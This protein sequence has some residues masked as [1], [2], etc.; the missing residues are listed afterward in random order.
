MSEKSKFGFADISRHRALIMGFAALWIYYF[1]I[2]PVGIFSFFPLDKIEWYLH[3]E[4]FCGVDIFLLLSSFGLYYSM[5]K[6]PVNDAKSYAGYLKSRFVRIFCVLIPIT[7]VIGFVD[8]WSLREFCLK[9]TGIDMLARDMYSY[10]WFVPCILIFYILSPFYFAVFKRFKKKFAFTL[11]AVVIAVALAFAL[12]N[13]I[14]YDLY[15]I[16]TRVSV[17][18]LGFYFGHCSYYDVKITAKH[19]IIAL[20]SLAVGVTYSYLLSSYTI[21]EIIPANNALVNL[22][23][24]PPVVLIL[25]KLFGFVCEYKALKPVKAFFAFFGA[26]SFEFYCTQEWMWEKVSAL[27]L[28]VSRPRL[29]AQVICFA[30]VVLFSYA[31]H[32]FSKLFLKRKTQ[33]SK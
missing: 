29:A 14:R 22:L 8:N 17:F 23:I 28:D 2:C 4:G 18:L 33:S 7:L 19:W 31:T 1:H 15:A 3:Q 27:S 25:S 12:K 32:L 13:V 16:V 26:M 21:K 24:A 5:S 30:G 20:V 11:G 6:K 9:V 10:L